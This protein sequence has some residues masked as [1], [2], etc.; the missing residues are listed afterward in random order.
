[1]IKSYVLKPLFDY[2]L[3]IEST[4]F[5]LFFIAHEIPQ[6]LIYNTFYP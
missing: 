5:F 2:F 1:M 6:L 3:K 4:D